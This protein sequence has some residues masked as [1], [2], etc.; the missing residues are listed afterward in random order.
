VGTPREQHK[1]MVCDPS[2]NAIEVK[3]YA[4][5]GAAWSAGRE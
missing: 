1:A 4:D 5:P 3:A 2:G